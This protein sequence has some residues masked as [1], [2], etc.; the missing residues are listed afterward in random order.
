[1]CVPA[2]HNNFLVI[3]LFKKIIIA[4]YFGNVPKFEKDRNASLRHTT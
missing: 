4:Q 2:L 3:L 1:M